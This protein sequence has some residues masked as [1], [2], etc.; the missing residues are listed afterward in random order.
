MILVTTILIALGI[1]DVIAKQSFESY[2]L[3]LALFPLS[4][5]GISSF[6]QE[7]YRIFQRIQIKALGISLIVAL[8]F[9][10][11]TLSL[12]LAISFFSIFFLFILLDVG[13]TLYLTKQ[14]INKSHATSIRK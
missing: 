2:I 5:L 6:L 13:L 11:I 10:L 9:F 3:V 1:I 12:N 4:Y 14:H 8:T 7:N